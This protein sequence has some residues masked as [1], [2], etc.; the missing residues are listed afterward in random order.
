[1]KHD[2]EDRRILR[3]LGGKFGNEE[4][5]LQERLKAAARPPHGDKKK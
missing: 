1:M 4:P 3:N 2:K 5:D